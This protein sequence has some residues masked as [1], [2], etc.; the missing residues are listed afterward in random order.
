MA[1]KAADEGQGFEGLKHDSLTS[2]AENWSNELGKI[3]RDL[4]AEHENCCQRRVDDW[5]FGLNKQGRYV[6]PPNPPALALWSLQGSSLLNQVPRSCQ[7]DVARLPCQVPLIGACFAGQ[8]ERQFFSRKSLPFW[9]RGQRC[10]TSGAKSTTSA[11]GWS[12]T[13]GA[14]WPWPTL[15]SVYRS[16]INVRLAISTQIE[17]TWRK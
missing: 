5:G 15:P 17:E 9:A 11:S 13:A 2:S 12:G 10:S 4:I 3:K 7:V 8:R 14:R 1:N 16:G 6:S